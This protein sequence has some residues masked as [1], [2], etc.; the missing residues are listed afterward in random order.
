MYIKGQTVPP[1]GRI[2]RLCILCQEKAAAITGGMDSG[3][4]KGC[5]PREGSEYFSLWARRRHAQ[6]WRASP[7]QGWELQRGRIPSQMG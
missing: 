1:P 5:M 3:T 6:P 7:V 2:P 4:P